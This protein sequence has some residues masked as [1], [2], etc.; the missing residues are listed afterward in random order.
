[1]RAPSAASWVICPPRWSATVNQRPKLMSTKLMASVDVA[2]RPERSVEGVESRAAFQPSASAALGTRAAPP[3]RTKS[4]ENERPRPEKTRSQIPLLCATTRVYVDCT[5]KGAL[6]A[7]RLSANEATGRL[8][9]SLL[10]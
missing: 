2:V 3:A 1:M 7:P 6:L 8:S 10:R 4:L 5:Q 9:V